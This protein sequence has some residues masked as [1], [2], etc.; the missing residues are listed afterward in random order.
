MGDTLGVYLAIN[1]IKKEE[2][3]EYNCR[4]SKPDRH[5]DMR[6]RLVEK[7]IKK[8]L[9][10]RN[11][12]NFNHFTV[13]E[14]HIPLNPVPWKKMII[15]SVVVFLLLLTIVVLNVQYGLRARVA[16]KDRFNPLEENG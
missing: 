2:L 3:G 14:E 6:V 12:T 7:G 1:N 4:I 9:L 11:K 10:C 16:L 13:P 8:L 5:I 15:I